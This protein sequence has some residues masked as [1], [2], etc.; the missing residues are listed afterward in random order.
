VNYKTHS[1]QDIFGNADNFL[2]KISYARVRPRCAMF[3]KIPTSD[4]FRN[5]K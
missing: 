5:L 4:E 2:L 1:R 3:P